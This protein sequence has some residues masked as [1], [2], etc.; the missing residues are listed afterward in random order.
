[1]KTMPG[2]LL[3]IVLL[4]IPTRAVTLDEIIATA[5]AHHPRL[6]A[7]GHEIQA[8]VWNEVPART[9]PDPRLEIGYK[10][11]GLSR[12]TLGRD[13]SS[14]LS[15]AATQTFPLFGKLALRGRIARSESEMRRQARE[16]ARREIVR[17]VKYAVLEL[18]V[19][20]RSRT[21]LQAQKELLIQ[22][23]TLS[24]QRYAAGLGVQGDVFKAQVELSR[25]EEM[26]L[27]LR[28]MEA[29]AAARL[30]AQLGKTP[31]TL[32]EL[33]TVREIP[34]DAVSPDELRCS[35]QEN[36][37]P[38]LERREALRRSETMTE[39]TRRERFPDPMVRIGWEFKGGMTDM[40][41]V[42]V[43]VE[44]P[45][46]AARR[47]VPQWRAAAAMS[48]AAAADAAAVH[49]ELQARLDEAAARSEN[50]AQ[51]VNLYR[52]RLRLQSR[53]AV[54][55]AFANYPAGRA[56]FMS[57]LADIT[58]RFAVETAFSRA[59]ADYWAARAELEELTGLPL[60][61]FT[62]HP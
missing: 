37:P 43:G 40:V 27:N 11:M 51:L 54:D 5:L 59:L 36:A 55:A 20:R 32:P 45:L 19:Q 47:Q 46:F 50:A 9:L 18:F 52:D 15:F 12:F 26:L 21:L 6:Q 48:R 44:I 42:M 8:L 61:D 38:L 39:L 16:T 57:L 22:A 49:L 23:Q 10:N 25:V 24:E 2:V 13:P 58:A 33:P 60:A 28:T 62:E 56:D 4:V 30:A 17:E 34:A 14:G 3:L 35:L 29:A 1:M 7:L 31:E 41:E 53:L